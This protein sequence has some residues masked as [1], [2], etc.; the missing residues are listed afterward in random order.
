MGLFLE[1]KERG[2]S[3][4]AGHGAIWLFASHILSSAA[5]SHETHTY[6]QTDIYSIFFI[7][8]PLL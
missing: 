3:A 5:L 8:A 1:K 2:G 4:G 7:E 6:T